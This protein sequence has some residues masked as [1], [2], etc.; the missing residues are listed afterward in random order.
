[1]SKKT[2]QPVV[3][4]VPEPEVK[5]TSEEPAPPVA[6]VLPTKLN[7][8]DK[9]NL[10]LAKANRR[11]ALAQA[12]QAIAEN[13]ASELSYKYFVLQLYMKYGL[14]EMDAIGENGEILRGQAPNVR[15]QG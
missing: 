4:A 8:F 6:P 7:D 14:N 11:A 3:A 2:Q 9:V 15:Q 12:K 10:D 1:M 5:T 13:E